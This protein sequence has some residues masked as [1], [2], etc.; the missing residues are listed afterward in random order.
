MSSHL[1][2]AVAVFT[3]LG[4]ACATASPVRQPETGIPVPSAWTAPV[5]AGPADPV[6]WRQ[7]GDPGLEAV[8]AEALEGNR[9]LRAASARIDA[10][11]ALARVSEADLRPTIGAGLDANARKQNFIGLPIPGAEDRVLSTRV[12]SYGVSVDTSWEADLWGRIRSSVSASL[13]DAQ[14]AAFET[15]AAR[16]SVAAQAAKVWFALIEADQQV[17]LAED[18]V[19]SYRTTTEQVRDRYERG[20]RPP[21]DLRLT[22]SNLHTAEALLA[23]RREQ[24]GRVA[25]QLE[26][27]LGRYPAG[28]LAPPGQLPELPGEVP[29]GMPAEVMERRP[30]L[31]AA[32]RR[33]AAADARLTANRRALYPRLALTGSGG[34][35]TNALR[36][37]LDGDFA[38]WSLAGGLTQPLFQGGRLRA[39]VDVADAQTREALERYASQVLTAFGEVEIALDAQ[40]HMRERAA[41]LAEAAEQAAAARELAE[42]RYASGLETVL[43]VLE[44]QRRQLE[45]Q[46]QLLAIRRLQLD[47]RVDLHLALGGD[48]TAAQQTVSKD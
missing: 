37:L 44:T 20:L 30:D 38:I 23:Q 7:F 25:R 16:L 1:K 15:G 21:S 14:A 46:S 11:A 9:D 27:L 31:Q 35:A 43:G 34:I 17:Q 40:A 13:A 6:W 19:A 41:R 18:T 4:A 24:F 32:E 48:F 33:L 45:A 5:D 3:A 8:V 28:A 22:L 26:V 12:T 2:A 47:T 42:Q 29:A 10:A 36:R 39:Q